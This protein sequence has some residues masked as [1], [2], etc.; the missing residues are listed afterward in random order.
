MDFGSQTN[1]TPIISI[2]N[3]GGTSLASYSS[4]FYGFGVDNRTFTTGT[5]TRNN[6]YLDILAALSW[7]GTYTNNVRLCVSQDSKVGIGTVHPAGRLHLVGDTVRM[8]GTTLTMYDTTSSYEPNGDYYSRYVQS[9]GSGIT[10][11]GQNDY[12]IDGQNQGYNLRL[13]G[14]ST[15]NISGSLWT[16]SD[17][18]LKDDIRP[19]EEAY[20]LNVI[21]QLN[22]V[23]YK[24][25]QHPNPNLRRR[26]GFIA[27]A[28][29]EIEPEWVTCDEETGFYGLSYN[30]LF[31]CQTKVIQYL[32]K[33][34]ELLEAKNTALEARIARLERLLNVTDSS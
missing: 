11:T 33:E 30:C 8:D 27:Q 32:V 1:G 25:K 22:P 29:K 4:Y 6:A 16:T 26:T 21:K 5:L 17:V 10:Y 19:V 3:G 12:I 13:R 23:S 15:F 14:F 7:S 20:A 28:V 31:S 2:Q 18:R 9:F 34:K 24:E